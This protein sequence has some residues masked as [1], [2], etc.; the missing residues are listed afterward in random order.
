MTEP[1]EM[2]LPPLV[3]TRPVRRPTCVVTLAAGDKAKELFAI[4][5]PGMM[6]YAVRCGADFRLMAPMPGGYP[7]AHKF[8]VRK[9]LD[10]FERVLFI[11]VDV[12]VGPTA[13]DLFEL[14]PGGSIGVHDDYPVL[15]E[16]NKLQ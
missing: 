10:R 6:R 13:P 8:A 5:G 7:L 15:A 1:I 4:S 2:R 16:Q 9:F 12:I 14:V 11:D 3:L